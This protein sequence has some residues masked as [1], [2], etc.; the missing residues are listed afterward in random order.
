M[1]RGRARYDRYARYTRFVRS[2]SPTSS[3]PPAPLAP[4]EDETYLG[5]A[6]LV[7]DGGELSVT[8]HLGGHCQPIDGSYRWYGRIT[9]APEVTAAFRAAPRDVAL[10]VADRPPAPARLTAVDP[11]G[12]VRVIGAGRAPHLP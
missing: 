4:P 2:A 1:R 5:P 10:R 7:T 8:V 3:D 11:W 12:N 9:A 6:T